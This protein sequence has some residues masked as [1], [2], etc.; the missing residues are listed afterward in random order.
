MQI[1]NIEYYAQQDLPVLITGE[2]GTGKSYVA[3]TLHSLSPRKTGPFVTVHS[4]DDSAAKALESEIFGC[5][6]ASCDSGQFDE[7]GKLELA[8]AGTLVLENLDELNPDIQEKIFHF[9]KHHSFQRVNGKTAITSNVR[10]L[11]TSRQNP[12][13]LLTRGFFHPGLCRQLQQLHLHLPPLTACSNGIEGQAQALLAP[14]CRQMHKSILGF[15]PEAE[16]FLRSYDWPGNL[17]ELH[18]ILERAVILEESTWI[19]RESLFFPEL[20]EAGNHH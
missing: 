11:G 14:I 8:H 3:H 19:Q 6:K 16:G 9:L 20:T 18:N 12:H 5:E 17:R 2:V 10:I 7:Q 1:P 4:R 15:S 13:I